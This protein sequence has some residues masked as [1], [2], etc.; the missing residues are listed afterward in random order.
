MLLKLISPCFK[1]LLW[2]KSNYDYRKLTNATEYG[3][4]VLF[5]NEIRKD[6][7][8]HIAMQKLVDWVYDISTIVDYLMPNRVSYELNTLV[9]GK[10]KM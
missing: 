9:S 3:K 8:T 5:D 1:D 7:S 4:G 6:L 2:W 10:A